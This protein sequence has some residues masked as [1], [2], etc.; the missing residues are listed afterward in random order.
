MDQKTIK[1]KYG[2][3]AYFD[4]LGFKETIKRC[5]SPKEF[6]EL[7]Q[8][9]E[10]IK[11]TFKQ[12]FSEMK[13]SFCSDSVFLT[14]ENYEYGKH[15]GIQ[16][17]APIYLLAKELY[18][19]LHLLFRGGITLGWFYHSETNIFGEAVN[20]AVE[21]ENLA[22]TSRILLDPKKN[23]VKTSWSNSIR[24]LDGCL[25]VNL[26]MEHFASRF[27][28]VREKCVLNRKTA[29]QTLLFILEETRTSVIR[30]C[31][32]NIGK[33]I[34]EKYLFQCYA[35]NQHVRLIAHHIQEIDYFNEYIKRLSKEEKQKIL[36]YIIRTEELQ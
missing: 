5:E 33:P 31:Q 34:A 17:F 36:S 30:M 7:F 20:R 10:T 12:R 2:Y 9:Y 29:F 1:Y 6:E 32:P 21:L 23:L 4:I 8:F 18:E 25:C 3:V 16:V 15:N 26:Y 24:D 14:C 27:K 22:K 19:R 35:Y 11:E 28:P 13:M